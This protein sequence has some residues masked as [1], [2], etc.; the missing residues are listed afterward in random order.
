VREWKILAPVALAIPILLVAC[1][2]KDHAYQAPSGNVL[3][4]EV[5]SADQVTPEE[6]EVTLCYEIPSDADWVLGRLLG[7]VALSDSQGSA[8]MDHFELV[9]LSESSLRRCD[10]LF[11]ARPG[12]FPPRRLH[13]H[14]QTTRRQLI[15]RPGLARAPEGIRTRRHPGC[16]APRRW[17]LFRAHPQAAGDE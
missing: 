5:I 10:R 12:G 16:A 2:S 15:A 6:A 14:D 8:S 7:D 11:F 3:R 17:P 9:A 13:P 1:S 4:L